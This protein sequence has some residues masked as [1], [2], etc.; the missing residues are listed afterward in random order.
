MA[1]SGPTERREQR[2]H[3]R[4]KVEGA[5]VTL[6]KPGLMAKL[7]LGGKTEPLVNLSRS[8]VLVLSRKALAVGA[9]LRLRIE[10]PKWGDVI[11][12]DGEVR[13]CAESARDEKRYY[14]GLHLAGVEADD[15][16][17]IE[18]MRK[19]STSAEYRA[20]AGVRKEG[21]SGKLPRTRL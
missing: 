12:C 19:L 14:A 21:S 5:T 11:A 2:A 17:R 4:F 15:L 3:P 13:W 8:G 16:R 9:W 7:G 1:D 10:I 6:I 18:E 20:M